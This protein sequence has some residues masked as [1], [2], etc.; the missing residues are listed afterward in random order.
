MCLNAVAVARGKGP[1]MVLVNK[2][3]G[4]RLGIAAALVHGSFTDGMLEL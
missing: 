4:V 1:Y 2:M 3:P